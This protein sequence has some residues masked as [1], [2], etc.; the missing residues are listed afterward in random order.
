[1]KHLLAFGIIFS[2]FAYGVALLAGEDGS[3]ETKSRGETYEVWKITQ[4]IYQRPFKIGRPLAKAPK[5]TS[6]AVLRRGNK[7]WAYVAV[8]LPTGRK[9]GWTQLPRQRKRTAGD[10]ADALSGDAAKGYIALVT[11]A[12]MD[13]FA[14]LAKRFAQS[15]PNATV[16]LEAMENAPLNPT[17]VRRFAA[18]GKLN[19]SDPEGR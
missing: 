18:A 6:L 14:K 7:L 5:G 9:T 16:D 1:M 4:N 13:Q 3:A 2:L 10:T 8:D 15:S 17:A 19:L 11:K 12:V